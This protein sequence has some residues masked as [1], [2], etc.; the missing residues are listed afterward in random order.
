MWESVWCFIFSAFVLQ[1]EADRTAASRSVGSR[2]SSGEDRGLDDSSDKTSHVPEIVPETVKAILGLAPDG[3]LESNDFWRYLRHIVKSGTSQKTL[4]EIYESEILPN[5]RHAVRANRYCIFLDAIDEQ[6]KDADGHQLLRAVHQKRATTNSEDKT[7]AGENYPRESRNYDIWAGAQLSLIGVVDKLLHDTYGKVKL[8]T[9]MRSEAF[10]SYDGGQMMGQLASCC[11]IEYDPHR[12]A[13]IVTANVLV[14]LDLH[15]KANINFAHDVKASDEYVKKFFGGLDYLVDIGR[16]ENWIDC[17]LR[18]TMGRPRELMHVGSSISIERCPTLS[19]MTLEQKLVRIGMPADKILDDFTKFLGVAWPPYIEEAVLPRIKSNVLT[20][21][22]IQ[23]IALALHAKSNGD[24]AH[25]F[26]RLYSLGLIGV[27]EKT[28]TGNL[29]QRFDFSAVDKQGALDEGLP[30]NSPYFLVHPLLQRRIQSIPSVR[31]Q[32]QYH[33]IQGQVIGHLQP[34]ADP[35]MRVR[36]EINKL[37]GSVQIEIDGKVVLG[38]GVASGLALRL[39][40]SKTVDRKAQ[41]RARRFEKMGNQPSIFLLTLLFTL[42]KAPDNYITQV[43][44]VRSLVRLQEEG[45]IPRLLARE[46]RS[47]E[48]DRSPDTDEAYARDVGKPQPHAVDAM[49]AVWE[50]LDTNDYVL[51]AVSKHLKEVLGTSITFRYARRTL[52]GKQVSSIYPD[53]IAKDNIQV[54]GLAD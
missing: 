52:G 20:S 8:F 44:Y 39:S 37:N 26:C 18:Q 31:R 5:L 49:K 9:S 35:Q 47:K 15:S 6:L 45:W 22:D 14:D 28:D 36:C 43:D 51:R 11:Q 27:V 40:L 10:H 13:T 30:G 2:H 16:H 3:R 50:A 21:T 7:E 24:I 29:I 34:W 32:V 19:D 54:V 12:L 33:P 42:A 38:P 48:V 25:P 23:E 53:G 4:A 1:A 46:K 17:V 41:A